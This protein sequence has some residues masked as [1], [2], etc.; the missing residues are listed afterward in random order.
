MCRILRVW[1]ALAGPRRAGRLKPIYFTTFWVGSGQITCNFGI[2][3]ISR[4]RNYPKYVLFDYFRQK[5]AQ[6]VEKTEGW[7]AQPSVFS[8]FLASFGRK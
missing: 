5:K 4:F 2:F 3:K 6:N 7:G 8:M 1:K